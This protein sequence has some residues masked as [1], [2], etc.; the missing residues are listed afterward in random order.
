MSVQTLSQPVST[1]P[2]KLFY[3]NNIKVLM[4]VLVVLHH[5]VITYGGPGGWYYA[6]KTTRT[7]ALIPMT[8]FVS[9]NQSFFMGFFFLLAAFFTPGS[10]ERKGVGKFISDRILRLGLPLIFYSFILS[11]LLSFLVYYFAKGNHITYLQYLGGFDS[12][13]DFGVLWFVAALLLFTLVYVLYRR[14][15]KQKPK[16][17]LSVPGTRAIFLFAVLLGIVSFF[18]RVEFPVGWVLKPV[19]F[20][21]GHFTQYIALFIAGLLAYKNNWFENLSFHTGKQLTLCAVVLLLFFPVFYV[22]KEKT[23]MP[24]SWY[25][26]GLHWQSLLYAVW[27]QCIGISILTA[28]LAA[29][30]KYWNRSSLFLERLSRSAF[31]VYILHPLVIISLS[32][33]ARNWAADPAIKLLIVAP[34]AIL[35]SFILGALFVLLPGVRKII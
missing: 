30:R 4:T 29:G 20:Q 25:S 35:G 32:M 11:P 33:A 31:A 22:I 10:Y 27:E 9:I 28:L 24:V 15:V 19:G 3:I 8:M 23:G 17:V 12:W 1:R 18:V 16:R 5:T 21:L 26:G 7:G 14:I 6:E 13:V 2:G 34:L